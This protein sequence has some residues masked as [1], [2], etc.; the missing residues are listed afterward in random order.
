MDWSEAR[1]QE[2]T[3]TLGTF[4]VQ[5]GF[6]PSKTA[7]VPVAGF[8]GVNL[9]DRNMPQAS[10]LV[11]WYSGPTLVQCLGQSKVLKS[12]H[13]YLI[14]YTDKLEPPGRAID[15]PLRFP[16]TNV[17]R[18]QIATSSG[19][20]VAGRLCSGVVQVGERLRVVPGDETAVVKSTSN[21]TF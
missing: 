10:E 4:L 8:L 2:I 14:L 20:A 16:V 11:K 5:S 1:F 6:H 17:F 19:F 21:A 13:M 3:E 7:F 12:I 18:G 9:L 15:A